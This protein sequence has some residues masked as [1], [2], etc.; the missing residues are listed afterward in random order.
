MLCWIPYS[1]LPKEALELPYVN[2][3]L[4]NEGVYALHNLLSS[5]LLTQLDCIRGIA[6]KRGPDI[7]LNDPERIVPQDCMDR[8]LPGYAS[9]LLPFKDKPLDLYRSH[10]WHGDFNEQIRNPTQPYIQVS[11]VSTAVSSA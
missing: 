1:A 2:T 6:C 11:V 10:V 3:A 9:D 5:D 4:L 8:D 7:I